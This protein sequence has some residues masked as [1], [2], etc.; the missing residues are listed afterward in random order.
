MGV[1]IGLKPIG[2]VGRLLRGVPGWLSGC[3][4]SGCGNG[5]GG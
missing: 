2:L 5:V 1:A 4:S 3:G